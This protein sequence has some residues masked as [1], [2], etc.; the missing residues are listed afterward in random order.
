M[1][2][3]FYAGSFDPFT[4]GHFHIVKTASKLFDKVIVGIGV[5]PQKTP[6]YNKEDMKAAINLLFKN[7]N[8]TNCECILF[9]GLTADIAM[10]TNASY[11]IRGLRNGM[12]YE[13][14]ENLALV[15][16]EISGLD[17][18]YIRA[19]QYGAVS[20]SM[21]YELIKNNKDTSKY[22]PKEIKDLIQ[23]LGNLE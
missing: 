16:Q 12:D 9:E 10:A 23:N 19:G 20:S 21:V 22:L 1:K 3:G 2:I 7:Q 14:E 4:I 6:R 5:N 17:T 15:N 8:L 13:F 18:I 11:L